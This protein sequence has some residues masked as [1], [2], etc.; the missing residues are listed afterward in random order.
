MR[1]WKSVGFRLPVVMCFVCLFAA[2]CGGGGDDA[3]E[4]ATRAAIRRNRQTWQSRNISSYRYTL[5]VNAFVP[6]EA[7]GPVRIEVRDGVPV[8]ARYLSDGEVARPELFASSNTINKLFDRLESAA[9]ANVVRQDQTFDPANGYP[10]SAYIDY[11]LRLA[12]DEYGFDVTDFAPIA[13]G[14]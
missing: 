4:S 10:I 3:P 1:A 12:D 11:D 13:V 14:D 6:A 8:S 2:G 9:E 5:R 7:R